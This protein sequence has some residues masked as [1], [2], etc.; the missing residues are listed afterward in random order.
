MLDPAGKTQANVLLEEKQP[1]LQEA[2]KASKTLRQEQS[3][4]WGPW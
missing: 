4:F 3:S 1:Q 2:E